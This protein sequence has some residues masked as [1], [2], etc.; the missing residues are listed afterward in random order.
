MPY[1]TIS[2]T[3]R[4]VAAANQPITATAFRCQWQS[5]VH[6]VSRLPALRLH[7]YL[8]I[9]PNT[10]ERTSSYPKATTSIKAREPPRA[11]QSSFL[12]YITTPSSSGDHRC[13]LLNAL[14]T[15]SLEK[16]T[17]T[18]FSPSVGGHTWLTSFSIRSMV[19]SY[20][21]SHSLPTKPTRWR[22]M[23]SSSAS[24]KCFSI[25]LRSVSMPRRTSLASY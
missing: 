2:T 19:L 18:A 17:S 13:I 4:I 8:A 23:T 20:D 10:L 14:L 3:A 1:F 16:S 24:P 7:M 12:L 11:E 25:R 6:T 5:A 15:S 21:L 22:E 9:Q